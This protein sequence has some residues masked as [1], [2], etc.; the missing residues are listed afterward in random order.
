MRPRAILHLLKGSTGFPGSH[1]FAQQRSQFLEAAWMRSARSPG[2]TASSSQRHFLR[3]SGWTAQ[4]LLP[5]PPC[6]LLQTSP[7]P[8]CP[9]PRWLGGGP[10][11]FTWAAGWLSNSLTQKQLFLC[12]HTC[13]KMPSVRFCH[14]QHV[15][16]CLAGPCEHP[17]GSLKPILQMRKHR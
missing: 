14:V 13:G 1:V 5:P 7:R 6:G 4:P 9:F 12:H 2:H 11:P 3:T 17:D 15:C 8:A 16:A 10:T